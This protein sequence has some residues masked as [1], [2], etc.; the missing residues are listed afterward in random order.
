MPPL[1]LALAALPLTASPAHAGGTC[2]ATH[3]DAPIYAGADEL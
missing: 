2:F 1:L 3:A